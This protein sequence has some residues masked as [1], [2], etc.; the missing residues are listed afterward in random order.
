MTA[1]NNDNLKILL[2]EHIRGISKEVFDEKLA[3]GLCRAGCPHAGREDCRAPA[4]LLA[5]H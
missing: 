2:D 1:G 4:R 3:A 5:P